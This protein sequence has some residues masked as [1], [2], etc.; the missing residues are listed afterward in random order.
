MPSLLLWI[1]SRASRASQATRDYGTDNTMG[2]VSIRARAA[3]PA[4]TMFDEQ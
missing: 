4:R 1:R 2:L 3:I